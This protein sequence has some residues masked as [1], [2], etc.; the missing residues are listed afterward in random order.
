MRGREGVAVAGRGPIA[1]NA[2]LGG[3]LRR[4]ACLVTRCGRLSLMVWL[5]PQHVCR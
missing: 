4:R 3:T 1:P 2:V 5:M